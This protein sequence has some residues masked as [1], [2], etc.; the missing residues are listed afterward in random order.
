MH[1]IRSTSVVRETKLM[2]STLSTGNPA[3]SG[4]A[5]SEETIS[6]ARSSETGR[7]R[8]SIQDVTLHSFLSFSDEKIEQRTQDP[9]GALGHTGVAGTFVRDGTFRHPVQWSDV[10]SKLAPPG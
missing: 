7:M 10:A 8:P 2:P 6:G 4:E 9:G 5:V 3:S 1:P